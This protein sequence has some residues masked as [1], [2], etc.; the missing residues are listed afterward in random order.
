MSPNGIFEHPRF[1]QFS[2]SLV[3][4]RHWDSAAESCETFDKQVN[5]NA[6]TVLGLSVI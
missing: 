6:G 4:C 3:S 2:R 5:T 1:Q